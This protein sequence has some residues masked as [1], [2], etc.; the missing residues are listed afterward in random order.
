M[1]RAFKEFARTAAAALRRTAQPTSLWSAKCKFNIRHSIAAPSIFQILAQGQEGGYRQMWIDLLQWPA[2][3]VTVVAA[4]L[5]SS[6][7]R[8][9]RN[10]GFWAFLLSNALWIAWA[11]GDR[12][13]A[14]IVLQICLAIMN[15]RGIRMN[16]RSADP[17]HVLM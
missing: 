12:A 5:V 4:W 11:A 14:M 15:I 2:T 16:G 9:R 8:F 6:R 13:Y 7:R 3:L 1:V 17:T 10:W